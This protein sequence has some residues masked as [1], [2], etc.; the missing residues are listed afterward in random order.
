MV[1]I[2]QHYLPAFPAKFLQQSTILVLSICWS[3]ASFTICAPFFAFTDDYEVRRR[4]SLICRSR[5]DADANDQN[6]LVERSHSSK[7]ISRILNLIELSQQD[8]LRSYSLRS[9][10]SSQFFPSSFRYS[11]KSPLRLVDDNHLLP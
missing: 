6:S 1:S 5:D 10:S 4:F 8:T 9:S 7:E 11:S 2:S 3:S